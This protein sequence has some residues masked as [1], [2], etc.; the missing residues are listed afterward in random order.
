MSGL[1]INVARLGSGRNC[2][3]VYDLLNRCSTIELQNLFPV[4]IETTSSPKQGDILPLNYGNY[5]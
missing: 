4:V 3:A 2:T 1:D 5:F